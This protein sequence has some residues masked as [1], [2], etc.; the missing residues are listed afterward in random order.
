MYWPKRRTPASGSDRYK[1][2]FD[3]ISERHGIVNRPFGANLL[4]D[5][6]GRIWTQIQ[7][8]DPS[9]DRL[10]ALSAVD[11]ADLGTGWFGS[12]AQTADGRMLFGGSKGVL[13]VRPE[14]F[15]AP[16]FAPAL[17]ATELHVDGQRQSAG[18]LAQG[19]QLAPAQRSFSLEFAALDYS[20]PERIRYAIRLDGFDPQW[21]DAGS[22]NRVA[23][24]SNLDPGSYL[25]RVRAT[26]RSGIWSPNELSIALQVLPSWWQQWWFRMLA[27]VLLA[28]TVFG[29]VQLRTRRLLYRQQALEAKV[30]QRTAELHQLT[31]ALNESSLT[32]PLTGLRNRRFFTMHI[33]PDAA[34]AMRAHEN[35]LQRGTGLAADSDLIFFMFDIDHFKDI[36]DRHG[37]AAGDAV[38]TQMRGRLLGVF[39]ETD[40]LVR[41]GGEEFLVVARG[42]SRQFAPELAERACAAVSNAPFE[43]GGGLRLTKTC[44]V[45][46]ASFPLCRRHPAALDWAAVLNVADASLYAVKNAGRNG[47]LGVLDVQGASIAEIQAGARLPMAVWAR[48]GGPVFACSSAFIGWTAPT[49][50]TKA[51]D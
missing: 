23:S 45:G 19:L 36:N 7:V 22:S 11:G 30:Q 10:I 43:I 5:G 3:R 35:H 50:A 6:R 28:A 42:T 47:W 21:I 25:L 4:A 16:D 17:V 27:L 14:S 51:P 48:T 26:N 24:Y 46:F 34:L 12:Y 20:D 38:L 41:W 31:D 29:F 37:H 49:V 39:R 9:T 18:N 15:N 40:Y 44:S 8:Y 1:A 33:A 2:C 32:D 13:V